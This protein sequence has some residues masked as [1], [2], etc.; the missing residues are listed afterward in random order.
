MMFLCS[1][2]VFMITI[3]N[4]VSQSIAPLKNTIHAVEDQTL[5]L[6]CKYNGSVNN[7]Q[8]YRQYPGSRPVYLLMTFPGSPTVSHATPRF[9][10]LDA[11]EKN[12]T[13]DL[14]ISSAE[15]SDSAL[16][17]CAMKPTVTG[18]PESCVSQSTAPLDSKV[19]V[20]MRQ[21]LSPA[22]DCSAQS[23]APLE[24][25]MQVHALQHETVTLS[26]RYDGN[27]YN[28]QWYRQYPG[29]RPEHLLMIFPESK[30]VIHADPPFPRLNATADKSTVDLLISSATV[31][32]SALY[33]CTLQPTV[34]GN[35]VTLYKNTG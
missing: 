13:L 9:P 3:G 29:S 16:Y 17:Y 4:C 6:S 2:A 1:L 14:I 35:P 32:D 24:N 27:V 7:L 11:K 5:T 31:S 12:K 33:Y 26:C 18:N 25:K 21:L 34:T 15:V 8:W 30:D 19:L 20:Q 23:I 28:L 22:K 10:R